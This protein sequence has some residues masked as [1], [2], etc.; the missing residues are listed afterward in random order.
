MPQDAKSTAGR[1][2]GRFSRLVA[3]GV[4][5]VCAGG[6]GYI[7]RADLFPPPAQ[8]ADDAENPQFVA[9]RTERTGHVTK[10][11]ADG[12]IDQSQHDQFVERAVSYCA[13]QFPPGGNREDAQ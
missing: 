13:A 4:F 2:N 9:C 3:L 8:Q 10:M 1:A 11:L 7:H 5:V 12:V 6:L